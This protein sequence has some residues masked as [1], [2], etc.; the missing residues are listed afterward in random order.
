MSLPVW[1]PTGR[2]LRLPRLILRRRSKLYAEWPA[3]RAKER[4]LFLQHRKSLWLE[5][6]ERLS[7]SGLWP[8]NRSD[9]LLDLPAPDHAR[10]VE[11]VPRLR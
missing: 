3:S 2:W 1:L 7:G 9:F 11:P 4:W 10:L 5:S 6:S 8:E